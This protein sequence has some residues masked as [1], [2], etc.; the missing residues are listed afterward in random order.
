MEMI[1]VQSSNHVAAG[2]DSDQAIMRI[3]FKDGSMYEYFDVPQYIWDE[4]L[5]AE[6]Q[7]SYAH[8][9]IYPPNFTQQK[10]A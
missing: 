1:P 5:A 8:Q 2:Y 6:S 10:I 3:E 9:N 4:Y 7:G